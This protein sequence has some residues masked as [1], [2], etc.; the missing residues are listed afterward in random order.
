MYLTSYRDCVTGFCEPRLPPYRCHTGLKNVLHDHCGALNGYHMSLGDLQWQT[1]SASYRPHTWCIYIYNHLENSHATHI[2]LNGKR[3]HEMSWKN[4]L[5]SYKKGQ[6][7]DRISMVELKEMWEQ[8][9]FDSAFE[10][11]KACSAWH[12]SKAV[13]SFQTWGVSQFGLAVR[14]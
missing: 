1:T 5:W 12:S 9:G 13:I 8:V 11:R 10:R 7:W 2:V 4:E 3:G 14:C 6:M